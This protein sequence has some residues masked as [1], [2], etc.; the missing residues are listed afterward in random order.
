[1]LR[2]SSARQLGAV[3]I[4]NEL[5]KLQRIFFLRKVTAAPENEQSRVWYF[6]EEVDTVSQRNRRIVVAPDEQRRLSNPMSFAPDPLGAPA[7]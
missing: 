3:K 6:R 5:G 4:G 2:T 1:M 7:A